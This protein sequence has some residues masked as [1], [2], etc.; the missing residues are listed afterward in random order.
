[1]AEKENEPVKVKRII[2][3]ERIEKR[4]EKIAEDDYPMLMAEYARLTLEELRSV[5]NKLDKVHETAYTIQGGLRVV[6]QGMS[7]LVL[8]AV[9][10]ALAGGCYAFGLF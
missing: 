6:Q 3:D 2:V 7:V 1:M 5:R 4:W 10:L 8:V 9:F